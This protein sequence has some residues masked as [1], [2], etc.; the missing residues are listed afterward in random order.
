M[1]RGAGC[2]V[3]VF[4]DAQVFC[5][6]RPVLQSPG[7]P[8]SSGGWN[9]AVKSRGRAATVDDLYRIDGKAELVGGLI[10]AE[11]P[12]GYGPH[13]GSFDIA[14]SLRQ[15]ERRVGGGV[16]VADNCA[17]LV[18]LPDRQS[19]SPDAAWF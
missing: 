9:M 7:H 3:N 15:H 10:I 14:M 19:F 8:P 6:W 11:P 1:M 4:P 2:A 5:I 12:T 18:D 17:F 16:A 13:R